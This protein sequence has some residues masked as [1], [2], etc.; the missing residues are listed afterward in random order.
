MMR[1]IIISTFLIFSILNPQTLMAQSS[2]SLNIQNIQTSDKKITVVT[3]GDSLSKK[4]S[5]RFFEKNQNGTKG[6][7]IGA[8]QITDFKNYFNADLGTYR[9]WFDANT[10]NLSNGVEYFIYATLTDSK[11]NKTSS[12]ASAVFVAQNSSKA[13]EFLSVNVSDQR[14]TAYAK[15]IKNGTQKVY[16]EIFDADTNKPVPNTKKS[17]SE[18][19]PDFLGSTASADY[20]NFSQMEDKKNYYVKFT[21]DQNQAGY[22]AS[23]VGVNSTPKTNNGSNVNQNGDPSQEE[24]VATNQ[25]QL[26]ATKVYTFLSELPIIGSSFDPGQPNAFQNLL[27]QIL[28]IFYWFIGVA[29]VLF[30]TW[31]GFQFMYSESAFGKSA[32][33]KRIQQILWGI[34][35]AFISVW[36]LSII[37]KDFVDIKIGAKKVTID[38]D[39]M[40]DNLPKPTGLTCDISKLPSKPELFKSLAAPGAQVSQ[41]L[42]ACNG[43]DIAVVVG[44]DIYSISDGT[45]IASENKCKEG[46]KNCGGGF[47]NYVKIQS[48]IAQ[49]IYAHASELYVK[50][51]DVVKSGSK[52]IKSGNT[53]YSS[54]PHLHLEVYNVRHPYENLKKGSV[55][56]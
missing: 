52:V 54:G 35:L 43:I 22:T 55:L 56:K 46:D 19:D 44:T 30:I 28:R 34:I 42:H 20:T 7:P 50:T 49:I 31:E 27:N 36:L 8:Q 41:G 2:T 14:V 13:Q 25:K 16:F 33:R 45:V 38:L 12:E 40:V 21:S 11:G 37:N 1:K 51:G 53:G 15:N 4:A 39:K 18:G 6:S 23:F 10:S 48:G 29:A 24:A 5:Y 17:F 47:G 9:Y 3:N 32:A 26:E